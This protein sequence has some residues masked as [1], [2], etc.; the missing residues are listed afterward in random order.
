MNNFEMVN[1]DGQTC[2]P[3]P[4]CV[5]P[6]ATVGVVTGTVTGVKNTATGI[7]GGVKDKVGNLLAGC[8]C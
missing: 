6:C 1:T 3:V 4:S 2:L 7:I 8:G 5:N